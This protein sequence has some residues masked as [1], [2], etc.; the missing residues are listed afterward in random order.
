MRRRRRLFPMLR[1]HPL[2]LYDIFLIETLTF[3]VDQ[4]PETDWEGREITSSIRGLLWFIHERSLFS[5]R[6]ER[7]CG[8]AQSF[9]THS[10]NQ[11]PGCQY[12]SLNG[13]D[14]E[15]GPGHTFLM[16]WSHPMIPDITK[17]YAQQTIVT[18]YNLSRIA[19]SLFWKRFFMYF[20]MHA[21]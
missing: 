5:T 2:R 17:R 18:L 16:I 11:R 21:F 19:R 20:L 13:E 15:V 7:L 3:S 4:S 12:R 9:C 6:L 10:S 8:D 14:S 1:Y